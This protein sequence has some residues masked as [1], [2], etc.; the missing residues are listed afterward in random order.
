MAAAK[1]NVVEVAQVWI[2]DSDSD[3]EQSSSLL[4]MCQFVDANG[5]PQHM[6]EQM[7]DNFNGACAACLCCRCAVVAAA[8]CGA[9]NEVAA[10]RAEECL[11]RVR[12]PCPGGARRVDVGFT[13]AFLVVAVVHGALSPLHPVAGAAGL[14]LTPL[15]WIGVSAV[16][17]AAPPARS[18]GSVLAMRRSL[19][20][21]GWVVASYLVAAAIFGWRVY[22]ALLDGGGR[23]RSKGSLLVG[24]VLGHVELA[25]FLC[26]AVT[27]YRACNTDPGVVSNGRGSSSSSSS[28][29]SSNDPIARFD[30][31]CAFIGG[32]WGGAVGAGNEVHFLGFLVSAI[33]LCAVFAHT[34]LTVLSD[35]SRVEQAHAYYLFLCTTSVVPVLVATLVRRSRRAA[36]GPARRSATP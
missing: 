11:D 10:Q 28:S 24:T 5:R 18:S 1:P 34:T 25:L 8:V 31:K 12:V 35:P 14:L 21:R 27:F 16:R 17:R 20:L 3:D 29:G 13:C 7:D 2:D 9:N 36:G 15:V 6:C 33:A 26:V 22:P 19:F 4:C 32:R 23:W 30:H